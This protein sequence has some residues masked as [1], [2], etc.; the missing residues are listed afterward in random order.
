MRSVGTPGRGDLIARGELYVSTG[1]LDMRP[2]VGCR[3]GADGFS[4]FVYA[5]AR[6]QAESQ[7]LISVGDREFFHDRKGATRTV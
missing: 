2:R 5:V 6:P 7:I 1:A 3:A 4:R